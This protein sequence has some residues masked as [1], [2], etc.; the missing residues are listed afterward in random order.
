M[1]TNLEK[2]KADLR[3]LF[4]TAMVMMHDLNLQVMVRDG[5]HVDAKERAA[6]KDKFAVEYQRWYTQA[7]AVVRQVISHRLIE[8]EMLYKGDGKRK[9]LE[10]STYTIQDWLTGIRSPD[11][12]RHFDE[13]GA[14]AMRFQAQAAILQSAEARF[15]SS[16]FDIRQ[17]VQADL[18]DSEVEAAKELAAKGFLRAAGAIAGVVLEK[19]LGEVRA[20]HK[21]TLAR[22]EPT[23]SDLNDALKAAEVIDVPTWRFIQRLGDLRNICDHNKERE[24]TKDEVIEL[25]AGVQKIM[26]SVF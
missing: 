26:K 16:L 24:P 18:F 5:K 25:I 17:L 20:N 15:E 10:V 13:L 21:I 2:Y 12:L 23:I 11:G 9:L 8:F 1:G 7:H 3:S 6:V 14:T 19:H 4:T 22:K